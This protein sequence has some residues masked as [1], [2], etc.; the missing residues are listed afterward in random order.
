M[1][2]ILILLSKKLLHLIVRNVHLIQRNVLPGFLTTATITECQSKLPQM[3]GPGFWLARIPTLLPPLAAPPPCTWPFHNPHFSG[4]RTLSFPGI[5]LF[6]LA[7]NGSS[8]YY[9]NL[10]HSCPCYSF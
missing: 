9:S 6:P 5:P 2:E 1:E 8:H 7:L 3:I 4:P 10:I